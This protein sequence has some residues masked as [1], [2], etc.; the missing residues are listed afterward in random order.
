[1]NQEELTLK[2]YSI[3]PLCGLLKPKY[4]TISTIFGEDYS[5]NTGLDIY[6]DLNTIITAMST[7]QKYLASLPF[8]TDAE[9]DIIEN[10]LKLFKHWKDY[11]RKWEDK[12]RIFMIYNS[13]VMK[14]NVCE[15]K[16]LNAYL[17][18]YENK[19]KH[20][21]F[22]QLTYYWNEAMKVVEPLMDYI[23]GGYIIKCNELDS[24]IIPDILSDEERDKLIISGSPMMTNHMFSKNT[25]VAYASYRRTGMLHISD[26]SMIVHTLTKIES[27]TIDVFIRNKVFYSL[28]SAI[29]GDKDRGIIGITQFGITTFATELLRSIEKNEVPEDPKSINSVLSV[30][31]KMYH[32]YLEKNFPLMNVDLHKQMIPPST[33]E[34]IKASLI[35]KSDIDAL[36]KYTIGDLNLM[37]LI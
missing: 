14:D 27:D 15:R 18:P 6:L 8:S 28:L 10:V 4:R 35:D 34:K 24:F 3:G 20:D 5:P 36:M 32:A 13:F 37:E 9:K 31:D 17:V 11:T 16:Q 26:P 30:V 25:Q 22:Q 19:F 21:R 33:I 29:I 7:S 2:P 23:P 1:M 12:V